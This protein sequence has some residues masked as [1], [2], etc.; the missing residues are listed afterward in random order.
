MHPE[1]ILSGRSEASRL[2]ETLDAIVPD[3]EINELWEKGL[4][5]EPVLDQHF[6]Q[7]DSDRPRWPENRPFA[8]C[9]T[10]DVDLVSKYNTRQATR[11]MFR[12]GK[13]FSHAPNLRHFSHIVDGLIDTSKGLLSFDDPISKF[14]KWLEV[15]KEVGASSTFFFTPE[16]TVKWHSSDCDYRYADRIHFDREQC[17]V[18]EMIREID[19]RGWEIGLHPSWWSYNNQDIM[20]RQKLQLEQVLQKDV[21]SVRQHF[22]HYDIRVTPLVQ[23]AVGFKYD[24]TLGFNNEIGFRNGT[25]YPWLV[26]AGSP[27]R[28]TKVLEIPLIIQDMAMLGVKKGLK[29]NTEQAFREVSEIAEKIQQVGGVLTLLWHPDTLDRPE[30]FEVYARLLHH[31]KSFNPW[32]ANLREVGEWWSQNE[33]SNLMKLSK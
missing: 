19:H 29:W 28:P 6:C 3:Y 32:F 12:A 15:E 7:I 11:K 23:E 18:A 21:V 1:A 20:A 25:S 31:L 14:E 24:S 10:H 33:N 8:V 13:T 17:T 26:H 4:I 30:I 22:L 27:D 5:R 9:L 2:P 16:D